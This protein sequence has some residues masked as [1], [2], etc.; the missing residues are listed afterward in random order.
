MLG[1]F[2]YRMP[3]W[4]GARL[5]RKWPQGAKSKKGKGQSFLTCPSALGMVHIWFHLRQ[6]RMRP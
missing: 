1:S 3:L 2:A 4:T 5:Q 6:D